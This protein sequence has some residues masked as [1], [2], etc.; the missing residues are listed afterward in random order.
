M[1]MFPRT[2]GISSSMLVEHNRQSKFI[3]RPTDSDYVAKT[4]YETQIANNPDSR[5]AQQTSN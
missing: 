1:I 2:P 5:T 4:L 3:K